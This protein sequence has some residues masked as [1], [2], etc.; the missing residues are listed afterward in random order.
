[1]S[2][3]PGIPL[4]KTGLARPELFH[5]TRKLDRQGNV[6]RRGSCRTFSVYHDMELKPFTSESELDDVVFAGVMLTRTVGQLEDIH[7]ANGGGEV[8]CVPGQQCEA[9]LR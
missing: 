8:I 7:S 2:K 5:I 6:W 3:P 4:G 9:L 1:M